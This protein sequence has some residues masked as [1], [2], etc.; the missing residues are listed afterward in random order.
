MDTPTYQTPPTPFDLA[1]CR[2]I[3]RQAM[4]SRKQYLAL[5]RRK[6]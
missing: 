4:R 3:E 5:R 2:A 1:H 6:K